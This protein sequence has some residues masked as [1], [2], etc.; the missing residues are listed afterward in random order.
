M[1]TLTLTNLRE[2]VASG[3]HKVD[4]EAGVIRDVRILG[5]ESQNGR[6]YS[7]HA[8]EQACR[9]YQ[10]VKVNIDPPDRS[11]PGAERKFEEGFGELR[12][13]KVTTSGVYGDLHFPKSHPKTALVIEYAERFPRQFGLSHNAEGEVVQRNGDWVVESIEEVYSVDIVGC[14]ATNAGLFESV[15]HGR[16]GRKSRGMISCSCV[17]R[18]AR[19]HFRS[20]SWPS[21]QSSVMIMTS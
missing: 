9:L 15:G 7:Q 3:N 19:R 18:L 13:C 1:L 16:T 21:Q 5:R 20:S 17:K 8:L 2:N 11:T 14:P 12:N 10:N 6:T 4:R